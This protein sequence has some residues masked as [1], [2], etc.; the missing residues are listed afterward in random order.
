M[1]AAPT[2]EIVAQAITKRDELIIADCD[3]DLC[4]RTQDAMF[5]FAAHRRIEHYRVITDEEKAK[6]EIAEVEKKI[7]DKLPVWMMTKR[8]MRRAVSKRLA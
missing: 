1:I 6:S 3:L 4:G 2:G 5:N 8:S 7:W